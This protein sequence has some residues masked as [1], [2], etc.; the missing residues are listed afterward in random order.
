MPARKRLATNVCADQVWIAPREARPAGLTTKQLIAA[1]GLNASQVR[2]GLIYVRE[3]TAAE[4]MAPLIW[5]RRDGFKFTK[6][7]AEL[8][9]FEK[10]QFL[11]ELTR[12]TRLIS[13]TVSPHAA[14][15]PDDEYAQL[16]LQQLGGVRA[17]LHILAREG[18][19]R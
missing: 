15:F 19:G 18:R 17:S 7:P 9:A 12:I 10:A 1:T 14:L 11:T 8:V 13:A 2:R 5:I 16:V 4:H 3:I 6:E